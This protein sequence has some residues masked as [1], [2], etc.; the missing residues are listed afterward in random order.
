MKL[1]INIYYYWKLRNMF[2]FSG[3]TSQLEPQHN[4]DIE[5]NHLE[6]A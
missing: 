3:Q 6:Q 5:L 1:Q 4:P 2:Q